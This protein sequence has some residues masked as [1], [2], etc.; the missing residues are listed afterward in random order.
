MAFNKKRAGDRKEW[1][2][3]YEST[4][5]LDT[6]QTT[7]S[8]EDFINK[9]MIHFSIYDNERSIPCIVDGLKTSLRKIL[10]LCLNVILLKKLK[11]SLVVSEMS[12]YHHGEASLNGGIIHM[13]QNFV[14]S[15]DINYLKPNGQF[16]TRLAGGTMLS[17]G[18]SLPKCQT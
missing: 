7:I 11:F 5:Y 9:E 10:L 6:N 8:Y 14:G 12:G 13:A 18:I 2:G 16:G 1:L 4:D 3:N 17:E 15:N